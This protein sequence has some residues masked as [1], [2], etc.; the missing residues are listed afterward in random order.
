MMDIEKWEMLR[1]ALVVGKLRSLH[2]M[3]KR[4]NKVG[5]KLVE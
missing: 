3:T 1:R 2:P 4:K 5:W